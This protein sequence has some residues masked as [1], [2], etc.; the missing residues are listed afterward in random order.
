MRIK[1]ILVI[2]KKE[3]FAFFNSPLAYTIAVPFLLISTFIYLRQVLVV[4]EAS[5][6][7]YFELLPW[8]LLLLAPALSM[9][10][11][12]DEFRGNTLEL[13]FAHP[14]SELEIVVGKF[15]GAVG[16]FACILL[17]TIGLPITLFVYARPDI[18]QI[19]G[20]YIGA[21]LL[22]ATFIAVGIAASSVVKNAISSFLLAAAVS[23]VLL[24]IGMDFIAL[25]LPYP[26]SLIATELSVFTHLTNLARGLLDIRDLSYFATVIMLFLLFA[27]AR[28]AQRKLAEDKKELRKLKLSLGILVAIGIILN[29]FLSFY[30]IRLD[31]TQAKLFTLSDGTKQ[32]IQKLP[33]ILTITV[34][35]SKNLPSQMQITQREVGDLLSDYQRLNSRVHVREVNPDANSAAASEASSN[36]IQEVTFNRIG[37]G[38]F[39]VQAGFLG[40]AMRYGGKVEA[41]PFVADTSD[42]EYQ[43]T[44]RIR[45]ITSEK[46]QKIGILSSVSEPTQLFQQFLST[47]YKIVSLT[48][49]ETQVQSDVSALI[50]LDDGSQDLGATASAMV[51]GMQARKGNVL[52]L[53]S[54][55]SVNVQLLSAQKSKSTMLN[56]LSDWGVRVNNDLI[57]DVE[58]NELLSF[59]KGQVQYLAPY[60][61]FLRALPTTSDFVPLSNVK[62]ISLGWPSSLA[63]EEKPGVNYRQLLTTGVNA[64]IVENSFTIS[65]ESV[66]NLAPTTKEKILLAA[67]AEKD[68][69][70]A[71]VVGNAAI[72]SDRF[73]QNSRDNVAFLSNIVD[74]LATPTD[75]TS[76][77]SRAGG[78][79]VFA[80]GKPTDV[81]IVQYGNLLVPPVIII[82]FA[83]WY[84]RRRR[85][86]SKRVYYEKS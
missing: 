49:T 9:K 83:I 64:G 74:W 40:I 5:M 62:S 41:I 85:M 36:G 38:K 79:S 52:L 51:K 54:G 2:A 67:V 72:A 77:P 58:L 76:I 75:L 69:A 4:G 60:P 30:P 3:F 12:T 16:F 20:Q 21:L 53:T 82:G 15:L 19:A 10:L 44:R 28:L 14:V 34:Y 1:N 68:G 37:A 8:F 43:L 42:L 73:L 45:K 13:L 55:V 17:S 80:F 39:E 25:M 71:V 84:L 29:I 65:P 35:V 46:E 24:I 61:F 70:R 31:V 26:A 81:Y 11:L 48:P 7:P 27:H 56:V 57:Y 78:R 50:I 23:F 32:T 63:I 22:G 86:L 47:Q 59:G 66:R 33:D 6:R 18:G